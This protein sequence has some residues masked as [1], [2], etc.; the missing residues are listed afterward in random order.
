MYN[1]EYQYHILRVKNKNK[2]E[3]FFVKKNIKKKQKNTKLSVNFTRQR[4]AKLDFNS[5]FTTKLI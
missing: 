1:T 4:D 5:V 3:L 2:Y